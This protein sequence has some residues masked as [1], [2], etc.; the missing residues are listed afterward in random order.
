MMEFHAKPFY[1]PNN[2]VSFLGTGFIQ[3]DEHFVLWVKILLL[4]T[5]ASCGEGCLASL[6]SVSGKNS[7]CIGSLE[8]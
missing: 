7:I 2:N 5:R 8:S 4:F 3:S 6:A 1:Q